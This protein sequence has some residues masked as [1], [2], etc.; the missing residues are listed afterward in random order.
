MN[1]VLNNLNS[2]WQDVGILGTFVTD[3]DLKEGKISISYL[4]KSVGVYKATFRDEIVYIG[5]AVEYK[6]GAL[7]KRLIDYVRESDSG[8][9]TPSSR[10]M[11]KNKDDISIQV[12]IVGEGSDCVDTTKCLEK[13]FIKEYQPTWNKMDK[14]K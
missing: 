13:L 6:N 5:R 1:R 8:R 9:E 12:L 14:N 7:R 10:K 2:L 3:N 4:N 11:F